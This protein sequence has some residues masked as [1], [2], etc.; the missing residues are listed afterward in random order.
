LT[1]R[2]AEKERLLPEKAEV[3]KTDRAE[4]W[5]RHPVISKCGAEASEILPTLGIQITPT[6]RK[7]DNFGYAE[8]RI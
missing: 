5:G 3:S 7:V 4:V 2:A 1:E 6:H 8:D